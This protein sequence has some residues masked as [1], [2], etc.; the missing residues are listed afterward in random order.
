MNRKDDEFPCITD[1]VARRESDK[2]LFKEAVREAVREWLDDQFKAFGKW[3]A[4]GISAAVFAALVKFLVIADI[5][6]R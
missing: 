5:W 4:V 2:D 3:T 6:P 1:F